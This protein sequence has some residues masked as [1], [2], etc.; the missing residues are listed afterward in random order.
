MGETP[1]CLYAAVGGCVLRNVREGIGELG[2]I[3]QRNDRAGFHFGK[4]SSAG[5]V[6]EEGEEPDSVGQ[7]K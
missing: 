5:S 4:T 2:R 1:R 6:E 7:K 3:T